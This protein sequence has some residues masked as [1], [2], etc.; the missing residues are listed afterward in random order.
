MSSLD[1]VYVRD[2][3]SGKLVFHEFETPTRAEV[4]QVARLLQYFSTDGVDSGRTATN[5]VDWAITRR[6]QEFRPLE[7]ERRATSRT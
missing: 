7:L 4:E 1:G 3:E 6:R 2:T 5:D